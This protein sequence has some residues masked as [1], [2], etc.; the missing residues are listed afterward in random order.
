MLDSS[1]MLKD[2]VPYLMGHRE[3]FAPSSKSRRDNDPS[4]FGVERSRNP[5]RVKRGSRW[6]L[7][8]ALKSQSEVLTNPT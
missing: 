5:V 1:R 6:N 2:K 8:Y 7:R 3:A 4:R